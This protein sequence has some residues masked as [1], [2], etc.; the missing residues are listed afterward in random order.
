MG[1]SAYEES[2]SIAA[3]SATTP[4]ELLLSS[5]LT[6]LLVV[7]IGYLTW[8]A[9]RLGGRTHTFLPDHSRP[10]LRQKDSTRFSRGCVFWIHRLDRFQ[11]VVTQ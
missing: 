9:W 6:F 2:T 1:Y 5:L 8:R 7:G 4:P 10:L 3:V 11:R